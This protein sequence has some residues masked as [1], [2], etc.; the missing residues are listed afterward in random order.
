MYVNYLRR[1]LPHAA[2]EPE[3]VETVRGSGYTIRP[4]AMALSA[5]KRPALSTPIADLARLQTTLI[6]G[7]A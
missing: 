7:A 4:V 5:P 3:I 2:G 1:K 6:A